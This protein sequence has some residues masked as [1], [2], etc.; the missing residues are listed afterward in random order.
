MCL[1][2]IVYSMDIQMH[3][4]S[5]GSLFPNTVHLLM[6]L[7]CLTCMKKDDILKH[8]MLAA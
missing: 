4:D 7:I 3:T 5:Y 2:I 6:Q 8:D 1:C